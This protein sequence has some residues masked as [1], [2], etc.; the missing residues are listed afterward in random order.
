LNQLTLADVRG[1]HAAFG[2]DW[3]KVFDLKRAL[4]ARR[5][6]GMPG[7]AQIAKQFARWKKTL[8]RG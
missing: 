8:G 7:P 2:A 3:N 5:G 6:T 1:V 4:A